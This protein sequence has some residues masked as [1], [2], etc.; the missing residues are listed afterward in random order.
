MRASSILIISVILVLGC[1]APLS[2]FDARID[3][4]FMQWDNKSTAGAA[5]GVIKDGR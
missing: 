3:P 5:V 1:T 4:I 2:D